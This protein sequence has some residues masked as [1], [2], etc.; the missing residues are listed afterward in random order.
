MQSMF[1]PTAV[2][3]LLLVSGLPVA[4]VTGAH[5][6]VSGIYRNQFSSQPTKQS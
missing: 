2:S 1:T 5:P 4:V 6:A 3:A